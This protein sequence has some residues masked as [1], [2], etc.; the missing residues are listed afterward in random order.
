MMMTCLLSS[1]CS[2]IFYCS[3]DFRL[4]ASCAFLRMDYTRSVTRPGSARNASP[5]RCRLPG[6]ASIIASICGNATSDCT[7][8]SQGLI[9]ICLTAAS[10]FRANALWTRPRLP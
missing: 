5:R 4:P 2:T 1:V 8:S 6:L 7:A 9:S 3:L 10:P